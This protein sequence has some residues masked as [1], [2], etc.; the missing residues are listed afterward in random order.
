[1]GNMKRIA[2]LGMATVALGVL[3]L[4]AAQAHRGGGRPGFAPGSG[5][6]VPGAEAE[7]GHGR[8]PS[9]LLRRLIFPCPAACSDTARTCGQTAD[10]T[11]LSCIAG[12]CASEVSAAQAACG[13]ET[14][15]ETCRTAVNALRTCAAS[16]LESRATARSE[17]RTA[18]ENCLDACTDTTT[19][20]E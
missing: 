14:P 13:P 11:A 20:A 16:C 7:G 15:T 9:S 8:R 3:T 4:A 1:M 5:I 17:C 12:A 10:E 18:A 2:S 6:G 19:T